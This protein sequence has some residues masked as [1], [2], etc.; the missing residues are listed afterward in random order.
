MSSA[1]PWRVFR[2]DPENA[3]AEE[4][5]PSM[6]Q[7]DPCNAC[8]TYGTDGR[9]WIWATERL[10]WAPTPLHVP[11]LGDATFT[12][13]GRVTAWSWH[14]AVVSWTPGRRAPVV[15]ASPHLYDAAMSPSG[16]LVATLDE[17]W[18]LRVIDALTGRRL[19]HQATPLG[20]DP[21][22]RVSVRFEGEDQVLVCQRGGPAWAAR[23]GDPLTPVDPARCA[24][25]NP[26]R[27]G[28]RCPGF[29]AGRDGWQLC[30]SRGATVR[31]RPD[32]SAAS[33]HVGGPPSLATPLRPGRPRRGDPEQS[34]RVTVQRPPSD[35]VT[36]RF[37]DGLLRTVPLSRED[38]TEGLTTLP[39]G[40]R[41]I[42]VTAPA[43]Y[44]ARQTEEGGD[45][46][47]A[48]I[49]PIQLMVT[50]P[51]GQPATGI[52]AVVG[53]RTFTGSHTVVLE[54]L[55]GAGASHRVALTDDAGHVAFFRITPG[56]DPSV[57]EVTLRNPDDPQIHATPV[58]G[59]P[60][61]AVLSRR[62]GGPGEPRDS[63]GR[64]LHPTRATDEL[65]YAVIPGV[66]AKARYYDG[67]YHLDAGVIDLV[68]PFRN[69]HRVS[70]DAILLEG[71]PAS[72]YGKWS[73]GRERIALPAGRWR[74]EAKNPAT[75]EIRWSEVEVTAGSRIRVAFEGRSRRVELT[76]RD[77]A[78]WPRPERTR[79][80]VAGRRTQVMP[81]GPRTWSVPGVA[82]PVALE[83]PPGT[84]VWQVQREWTS[85]SS[86]H[87]GYSQVTSSV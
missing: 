38:G 40:V 25:R 44:R 7:T 19:D 1:G 70:F 51:D 34:I 57:D 35:E 83:V 74:I 80:D 48:P 11:G 69:V 26:D 4:W 41:P 42:E 65:F 72:S 47:V 37:D 39:P 53:S 28:W 75:E 32:G 30:T 17:S 59:G 60:R 49:A 2:L 82:E 78:G 50:R 22:V 18:H 6:H 86:E 84:G 3:R 16:T 67:A 58:L 55:R 64:V 10:P 77:R 76:V 21:G 87:A 9:S 14:G 54:S 5:P 81:T 33:P 13:E 15:T 45:I 29:R 61:K 43:G 20:T 8:S 24:R 85:R 66:F 56:D 27:V 52:R 12:A 79:S 73:D 23:V 71:R 63:E 62:R 36:I 31:D 68:T 46:D